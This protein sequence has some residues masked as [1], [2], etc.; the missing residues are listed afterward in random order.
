MINPHDDNQYFVYDIS[1]LFQYATYDRKNRQ[2]KKY[3][4][5]DTL[6]P[7]INNAL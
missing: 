3:L 7:Q 1:H 4:Q 2:R 6:K 5:I